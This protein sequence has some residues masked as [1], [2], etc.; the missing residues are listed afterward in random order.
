MRASNEALPTPYTFLKG[1]GRGC[2]LL[3]AS[4]DHRFIVGALRARRAPGRSS[5][6][7]LRPRVVRAQETIK[8]HPLLCSKHLLK[9][10]VKV[11]L[12]G[13]HR[14]T[15]ALSWGLCEQ[16]GHLTIPSPL[17]RSLVISQRWGLIDLPLR[18]SMTKV[19][20]EVKA[21][22]ARQRVAED[23]WVCSGL[24]SDAA[25]LRSRRLHELTDGIK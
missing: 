13:A 10:T 17:P 6:I 21:E 7:L 23:R 9:G 20:A 18:A 22:G 12:D 8:L 5:L 11:A 3:R 19:E 15:T 16:K 2:P 24:E 14:A 25:G 1:S 4:S